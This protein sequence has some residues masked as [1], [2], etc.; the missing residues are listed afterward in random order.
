VTP[1]T[2]M[3]HFF[4]DEFTGGRGGRVPLALFEARPL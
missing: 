2:N 4:M 1:F 3:V